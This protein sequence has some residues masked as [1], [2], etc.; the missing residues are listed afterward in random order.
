MTNER[1]ALAAELEERARIR[2]Q[3]ST[4]KSV[5]EGKPDRIADLLE[6]AARMLRQTTQA[7][8]MAAMALRAL[9]AAASE[10]R[11]VPDVT[12]WL[13]RSMGGEGPPGHAFCYTLEQVRDAIATLCWGSP[14][15]A[16][17]DELDGYMADFTDPEQWGGESTHWDIKFEIDGIEAFK[18]DPKAMLSAAPD[19]G[20]V[21]VPRP[22]A[23][24]HA[25]K[26]S[27][28]FMFKSNAERNET[29]NRISNMLAAG[30][31]EGRG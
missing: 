5:Q 4:R 28:Q 20:T 7:N 3:I 18:L 22:V 6:R 24:F 23:V 13:V 12:M 14:E 26:E 21:S 19:D 15:S 27:I 11:V 1:E 10:G 2:R 8:A 29:F 25:G 17:K 30:A 16:H 9:P 31:G